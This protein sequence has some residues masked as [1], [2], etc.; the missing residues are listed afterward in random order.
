LDTIVDILW[1]MLFGIRID[2]CLYLFFNITFDK[3]NYNVFEMQFNRVLVNVC[4]LVFDIFVDTLSSI[5]M[6]A[7]SNVEFN[8]TF[9]IFLHMFFYYK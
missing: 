1:D 7:A 4:N 6:D 8:K 9:A 3:K 2:N 5:T